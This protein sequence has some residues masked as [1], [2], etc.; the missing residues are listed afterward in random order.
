LPCC[1][2]QYEGFGY[3]GAGVLVVVVAAA[4][5]LPSLWAKRTWLLRRAGLVCV[6]AA[7][8]TFFAWSSR[9]TLGGRLLVD[10]E[11]FY[12]PLAGVVEPFRSSGRFIWMLDYLM[13]TAAIGAV[14]LTLR[15]RP[16]WCRALFAIAVVVQLVDLGNARVH[17]DHDRSWLPLRAPEWTQLGAQTHHLEMVPPQIVDAGGW[18]CPETPYRNDDYFIPFAYVAYRAGVTLNSGYVSRLDTGAALAACRASLAERGP[19]DPSVV[20]VV[21]PS[22]LSA[23]RARGAVCGRIDAAIVCVSPAH[24][25]RARLVRRSLR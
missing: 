1:P 7:A 6:A 20:Y 4:A 17:V 9:I 21:D 5:S 2:G 10:L 12:R 14:C 3:L 11:G 19:L 25:L 16:G 15:H 8:M 18:R 23:V 24:P 22:A 13:M